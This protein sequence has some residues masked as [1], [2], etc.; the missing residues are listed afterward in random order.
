M[1]GTW[2][3][4]GLAADYLEKRSVHCACCGRMIVCLAWVSAGL[5]FCGPACERMYEA[6]LLP[7]RNEPSQCELGSTPAGRSPTS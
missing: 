6:Y 1:T 2:E 5:V 7:R 4:R 3:E